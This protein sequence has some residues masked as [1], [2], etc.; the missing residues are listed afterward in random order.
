MK[1]RRRSSP[2]RTAMVLMLIALLVMVCVSVYLFLAHRLFPS[3]TRLESGEP[4][5]QGL[6]VE[7][8]MLL[9]IMLG[10]ALLILFFVVG[11]YLLIRVGRLVTRKSVGGQ[12]TEY[13]DAWSRYRLSDEQIDAA[14]REEPPPGNDQPG[15]DDDETGPPDDNPEDPDPKS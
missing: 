10:A 15:P 8:T 11:S 6:R 4:A 7:L 12:P 14:T 5:S 3:A 13:V 2:G 1:D 9:A